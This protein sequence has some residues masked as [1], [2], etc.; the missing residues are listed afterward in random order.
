MIR[1][2]RPSAMTLTALLLALICPAGTTADE[3]PAAKAAK[4]VEAKSGAAA[5]ATPKGEEKQE[6]EKPKA[7]GKLIIRRG[8][9]ANNQA[10][11]QAVEAWL[12]QSRPVFL[13]ELNFIRQTCDLTPQ[14]R[15]Q[16][17]AAAEEALLQVVKQFAQLQPNGQ[18]AF[19]VNGRRLN[20]Q[21]TLRTLLCKKLA[22]SLKEI[23]SAE[24]LSRYE[25]ESA[26][27]AA[28]YKQAAIYTAVSR[29]DAALFL[30][31][32]QREKIMLALSEHWQDQWDQWRMLSH[33]SDMYFPMV[34]DA[35]IVDHLDDG[36]KAVWR[37]LQKINIGNNF[38]T[39]VQIPEDAEWWSGA[40]A[41]PEAA[42][43][44]K[45]LGDWITNIK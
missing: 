19:V 26:A 16:V 40:Q 27:R 2:L 36:Q 38:N 30:R 32:W 3:H 42:S 44:L 17:K 34:P 35:L 39:G 23:L 9:V 41:R 15:P 43:V 20:E 5:N 13:A 12:Q 11:A 29:I 10:A 25:Q 21:A 24:Q 45:A 6:E 4:P 18:N 31:D 1:A 14:Q 7:T 28:Q 22:A 33:Y 8:P 37:G